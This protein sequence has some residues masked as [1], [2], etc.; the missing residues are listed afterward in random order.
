[1]NGGL[2]LVTGDGINDDLTKFMFEE[3]GPATS[4]SPATQD[5][6]TSLELCHLAALLMQFTPVIEK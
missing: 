2:E 4:V 3:F 1:M 6:M 5:D